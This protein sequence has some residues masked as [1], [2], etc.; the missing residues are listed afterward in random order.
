MINLSII[1][2]VY[3]GE[4]YIEL[5]LNKILKYKSPDFEIILLNDGSKDSTDNICNKLCIEDNRIKYVK[6]DNSGV[7]DT[8][9][10][11]ISVASGKWIM[12]VDCDDEL[13]D[14]WYEIISKYFD[15]SNDIIF[16]S[17]KSNIEISKE[18]MLDQIFNFIPNTY[19]SSPCS[20][21]YRLDFLKDKKIEFT[22]NII[23][24]EDML[25]NGE[26]VLAT[27]SYKI[28]NRGFYNYRKNLQSATNTFNEKIFDSDKMFINQLDYLQKKY[29][30]SLQKCISFSS[31]NKIYIFA[32]RLSFIKFKDVKK[33]KQYIKIRKDD[34]K[35][36]KMISSK[37]KKII[38]FLLKYRMYFFAIESIKFKYFLKKLLRKNKYKV[39]EVFIKI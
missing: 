1:I 6:K 11:G 22:K 2:P 19:L 4:E 14:E 23:N 33:Y 27:N 9:N 20:R 25:F 16:F 21:L 29:N 12:F 13:D 35:N 5:C 8:R 10:Y 37:F 18:K 24:G 26:C 36:I 32:N 30:Y 38:L 3:N 17:S 7:S 15:D 34:Y 31:I 39:K 28:V